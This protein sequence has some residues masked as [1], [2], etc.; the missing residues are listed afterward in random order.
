MKYLGAIDQGTSSTRFILFDSKGQ[1]LP[2]SPT[3]QT[4]F[5]Q[6]RPHS[7]WLE[8]DPIEILNTVRKCVDSV[9]NGKSVSAEEI[10]AVGITNQRET[11]VL[12]DK[13]TGKPLHN[14]IVWS[15]TRTTHLVDK[16]KLEFLDENVF[17]KSCGLPLANY[18]SAVKILWMMIN[19]KDVADAIRE[20]K[21]LFGTV[22]TWIIW[23]LTGGV[24]GGKHVTD[25]SNASRTMLM[26]LATLDWDPDT[27]KKLGIPMN[28]LPK[29]QASSSDFGI[30]ADGPLKGVQI[31]GV[32]RMKI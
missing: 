26:N 19:C 12:W 25:V 5:T 3:D 8:H 15:D 13:F 10:A 9:M 16:L 17:K 20:N 27:C 6:I 30:I 11:C 29:I 2:I 23:N 4:E 1:A 14:A 32:C 28:I 21:C 7:G 24:N 22:D 31:S 18:F